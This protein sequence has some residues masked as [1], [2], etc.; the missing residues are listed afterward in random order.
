MLSHSQP[1]SLFVN[2]DNINELRNPE[3]SH[4]HD[5]VLQP[6]L[7]ISSLPA[8]FYV[9]L[10][11]CKYQIQRYLPCGLTASAVHNTIVECTSYHFYAYEMNEHYEVFDLTDKHQPWLYKR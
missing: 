4:S 7:G 3:V 8:T 5:F 10:S 6:K 11:I 9:T 1:R 2:T